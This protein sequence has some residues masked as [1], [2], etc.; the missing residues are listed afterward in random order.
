MLLEEEGRLPPT[1]HR[2]AMRHPLLESS[3]SRG[4]GLVDGDGHVERR[5]T[6]S[7]IINRALTFSFRLREEAVV[8]VTP[9]L[10]PY[11]YRAGRPICRKV[12]KIMPWEVLPADWLIL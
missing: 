10:I 5:E 3:N 8:E 6:N 2:R 1:D 12:L 7:Y 4:R 9:T 11:C